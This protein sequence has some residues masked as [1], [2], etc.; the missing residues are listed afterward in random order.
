MNAKTVEYRFP[1]SA[2]EFFEN[3]IKSHSRYNR[4]EEIDK[5]ALEEGKVE[6]YDDLLATIKGQLKH[7]TGDEREASEK[8]LKNEANVHID[9]EMIMGIYLLNHGTRQMNANYVPVKY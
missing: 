5:L 9:V 7:L 6:M 8:L 1:E 2:D 3:F 4:L